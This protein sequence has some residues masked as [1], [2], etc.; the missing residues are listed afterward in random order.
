MIR[1]PIIIQRPTSLLHH[2]G[3]F[4]KVVHCR[5]KPRM[6]LSLPGKWRKI[7]PPSI[8][9]SQ[10]LSCVS[11]CGKVPLD[12]LMV[13]DNT[14][15]KFRRSSDGTQT[16]HKTIVLSLRRVC[17]KLTFS[18]SECACEVYMKIIMRGSLEDFYYYI[19]ERPSPVSVFSFTSERTPRL[20]SGDCTARL[21]RL[22]AL[23][24]QFQH[25]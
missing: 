12:L 23:L 2:T 5:Q 7:F 18:L 14:W 10:L 6:P 19:G 13:N 11:L 4:R 3:I 8:L 1:P 20:Y 15:R 9:I 16:C 22:I 17:I 21:W 25:V 24:H